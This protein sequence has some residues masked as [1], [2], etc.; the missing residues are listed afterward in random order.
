MA[1]PIIRHASPFGGDF[2]DIPRA[3]TTVLQKGWLLSLESNKAVNMDAVGEDATFVGV[4]YTNH[5]SGDV[6]N[7]TALLKCI[8]EIDATSSTFDIGNG[9]KYAA[10]DASTVYSVADDGGANT[11]AN[12]AKQYDTAATRILIYIDVV[13]L[14]K[15][16]ENNA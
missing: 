10:G 1:E 14:A 6:H 16:F 11:I 9:V 5:E 3:T 8:L 4:A 7:V 2:L 13:N 12:V 15:L